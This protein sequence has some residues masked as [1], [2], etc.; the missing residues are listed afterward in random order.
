[1]LLT[2]R[3]ERLAVLLLYTLIA[4]TA[5]GLA[6]AQSGRRSKQGQQQQQPAP[7]PPAESESK[8]AT[9][10]PTTPRQHIIVVKNV[11]SANV[12][13]WTSMAYRSFVERLKESSSLDV[14]EGKEMNR[15]EAI[16]LAK[17]QEGEESYVVWLQLE[18]DV[19]N[20]DTEGVGIGSINPGCLYINYY[21]YSPRTGKAK[22]QGKVYQDGYQSVC[23]GV[24][25]RPSPLPTSLPG[26]RRL[27]VDYTL[28]KAGREA[29]VRVLDALNVGVRLH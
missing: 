10:T 17:K 1:M 7:A 15:K 3:S 29:A 18:M 2:I 26:S 22:A 24:P 23:T 5:C 6:E 12:S 27:P 14:V 9:T 16:E 8:P 4:L 11:P 13:F 20:G 21:L 19:Y 25:S 28:R